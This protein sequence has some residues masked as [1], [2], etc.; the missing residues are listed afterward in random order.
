[1]VAVENSHHFIMIDQPQRLA[2]KVAA[3]LAR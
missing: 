2:Q 3:F 1:M